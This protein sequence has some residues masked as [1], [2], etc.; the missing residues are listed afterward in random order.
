MSFV[1]YRESIDYVWVLARAF[2]RWAE[3]VA[4]TGKRSNKAAAAEAVCFAAHALSVLAAPFA[5]N[6]FDLRDCIR[7]CR[8]GKPLTALEKA[9]RYVAE[10]AR[11]LDRRGLLIRRTELLRGAYGGGEHGA[12]TLEADL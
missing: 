1:E 8:D 5:S 3:A 12:D 10:L 7:L 11:E 2:D 9:S 4:E 6:G